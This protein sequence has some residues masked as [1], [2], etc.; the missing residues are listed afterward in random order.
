MTNKNNLQLFGEKNHYLTFDDVLLKPAY[1]DVLP[2][3]TDLTTKITKNIKLN[4]PIISAAMDTVTESRLSIAMAE[5]GGMGCIHKNFSIK[6]QADEVKK[7]KKFESGVVIDPVTI[8]PDQ[9][10]AEALS[11][12]KQYS[13]S[14]IPVVKK[15]SKKLVGIL[16]NRDVRFAQDKKQL[17]SSLMTD[18]NLITAK[19]NI[20]K[21]DARELLHKNRIERIIIVDNNGNCTGL[22]T[23]KDL[24]KTKQFPHACKDAQ[25]RL[26]VSA[27]I[28][29]GKDGLKRAEA[30]IEAGVDILLIDTSHGHSKGVIETLKE[31]KKFYPNKDI[32]AGNIA[33]AEAAKMLIDFGADA[34]KVG[35][36]PGSICTT[37]VV[38]GVG[39]PQLSA[40]LEVAKIC[41][42][43]K[44]PVI[45][46][47]GIRFS[48]DLAKAIAAGASLVM[49]GSL[50]AG[51]EETPGEIVL[52]KGRSYKVYRGM[53]SLGAMAKGSA[54]RYFQQDITDKLKFVPQ[55]VEGRVAYKGQ[56][57]EVIYQLVGGLKSAMGYTGNSNIEEMRNNCEFIKITN[58]GLKENHPHSITITSESPNYSTET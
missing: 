7:V 57:S 28:G 12:M 58:S 51:T 50:L 20:S 31:I 55:G 47:G 1:S 52:Y 27:A 42:L 25:G 4:V 23:G 26:R 13:I 33:T 10:L 22:I 16:T 14:G 29:T 40:V 43:A 9:T 11:L 6:E 45:S 46:D 39:V 34:V 21:N 30:L 18:K 19:S 5:A 8:N 49:L 38:A 56:V 2:S 32:I 15:D 36:G 3:D 35:I 53:G 44:I 37:R 54:D 17:V 24:E 48:G 41:N